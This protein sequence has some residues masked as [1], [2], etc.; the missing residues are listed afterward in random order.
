MAPR[1]FVQDG[2][3]DLL[4]V[5]GGIYCGDRCANLFQET[6]RIDAEG[7]RL[8]LPSPRGKV[9]EILVARATCDGCGLNLLDLLS[10]P[11]V[12]REAMRRQATR[13][14]F[15]KDGTRGGR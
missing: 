1:A 2:G 3:K 11:A 12:E 8:P 5:G 9:A 4:A 14:M 10:L 13:S 7:V 15:A 6:G